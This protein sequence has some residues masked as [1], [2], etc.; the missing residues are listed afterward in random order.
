[1]KHLNLS[2]REEQTYNQL[3]ASTAELRDY[4]GVTDSTV[5]NYIQG[6]RDKGVHVEQ[7]RDGQYAVV[8]IDGGDTDVTNTVAETHRSTGTK[9]TISRKANAYLADLEA[10]IKP[11][12]RAM[13]P[14]IEAGG[15]A[16]TD[17][18]YDLVIHRTDDH[19]GDYH[20]ADGFVEFTSE[21]AVS[22]ITQT[23]MSTLDVAEYRERAGASVDT[24]VLLLGGDH[25]TNEAIHRKQPWETRE[26]ID[27]QLKLATSVYDAFI[28]ML[29]AR[30]PSVMVVCQ[31][32]NHGEFR[33]DGS[34]DQANADVFMFD[35]LE[36]LAHRAGYDNVTFV[37]SDHHHYVT[38]PLRGGQYTGYLTHGQHES[39]HIGTKS[40]KSQWLSYINE[41]DIDVAFR[42]H[43]HEYKFEPVNGVPVLMGGSP[44][45]CGDY[46]SSLGIFGNPMSVLHGVTDQAI[47]AWTE[48]LPHEYGPVT[49]A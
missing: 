9:Q 21:M 45:P 13:G 15:R 27:D 33:V 29:A 37:R 28:E 44:K 20:Y 18:G 43:Y 23:L 26:T 8:M 12:R 39:S 6:L 1:M 16:H 46:E 32:G 36:M 40:P 5:Y 35:N 24:L 34:S 49:P 11:L 31:A 48:Y 19:I 4:F 22:A 42:G 41:F 7:D 2:P 30:F 25:V 14:M 17:D 3:P 38:F 10:E 47:P